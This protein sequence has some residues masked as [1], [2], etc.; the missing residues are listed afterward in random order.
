LRLFAQPTIFSEE[1]QQELLFVNKKKQKNFAHF[2]PV[3]GAPT[4]ASRSKSFLLLFFKKAVLPV[5]ILGLIPDMIPP[6]ITRANAPP[7]RPRHPPL[8]SP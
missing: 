7:C 8:T 2:W 3:A 1:S 6:A 4:L 5:D